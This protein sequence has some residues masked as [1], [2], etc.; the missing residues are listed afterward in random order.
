MRAGNDYGYD[1]KLNSQNHKYQGEGYQG[2]NQGY[3]GNDRGHQGKNQG[4]QGK[5]QG[6]RG[7]DQG[8][9]WKNQ[10][11]QGNG[12]GRCNGQPYVGAPYN[13][14][15][16]PNKVYEYPD[17]KLTAHD[18]MEA[19]LAS[20][21]IDY[22]I[23]AETPIII[24][25]GK[26]KFKKDAR[27]RY[28]IPGSTIRGLIRNNVQI[29]GLSG[30]EED[31]DD[32]ALMYRN[33]AYGAEK[34]RYNMVLG[35]P[36]GTDDS[37]QSNNIGVLLNVRAGY[38]SN[39]KGKYII[40]QTCVDSIKEE[41]KKMN[42][43][44]LSERKIIGDYLNDSENFQYKVF[45]PK[46]KSILQHKFEEFRREEKKGRV[47]YIGGKNPDYKPYCIQVSYRVE[48]KK[49][50]VAV[51][52]PGEY[53]NEGVA[54]STGKMNQKKAVYIIP[55]IDKSKTAIEIPERDIRAF[56]IDMKKKE[57]TL[58]QFGGR[59]YFD[60][61]EPGKMKPIFY[62]QS[63]DRLYFGFT[64][65]LRLFYDHTIKEGLKQKTKNGQIDYN[66]AMFGY[67]SPNGSYRSKI[68]FS[69]AVVQGEG[70]ELDRKSWILAEPKP[71]S[72]LDY[73]KPDGNQGV[74]Y[75]KD[76]F[77]L[78][79]VKQ[80]WLH[81]KLADG[82]ENMKNK[83]KVASTF[84]ALGKGTKFVGKIRFRN[85]TQDELGLLLWAVRL[86]PDSFMNV[87]KAKAYGYG[88]ISV[89][90][91]DAKRL[92]LTAAY[93]LEGSLDMNPFKCIDIDGAIEEYK[94]EIGRF[95]GD[96]S[97]DELPHIK[98]FFLM[99]DSKNIPDNEKT[100]YMKIDAKEYQSRKQ[101]LP[102]IESVIRGN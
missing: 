29:L 32:Y 94:K 1:K 25:D 37:A 92:D 77:E 51:G 78:R 38:V 24:D 69:D 61:P 14:V 31:I 67:A 11:Y 76:G 98:E 71:T 68:S 96:K 72:Y 3:R 88:N 2:K 33:V 45:R 4:H 97:I 40:Y 95:L 55:Q 86:N 15:S 12:A 74:T 27:G 18:R 80:Y 7:N 49:D 99:K 79:G 90:I 5:S 21:E 23:Q 6:Y 81:N 66:K 59:Q 52:E 46:G 20:G 84:Q 70:K 63:I 57:K 34:K 89:K 28:A 73:L 102:S 53:E 48:D 43:Y 39:E 50:I 9:Q 10:G 65:R 44:V 58:K 62:V 19:D 41:F 60:L 82:A 87:G 13:F 100:R 64:P 16:F 22:E 54:V 30:F 17:D 75:N 101:V 36:P 93:S 42:Y 8:Y 35:L 85:L 91:T 83:D 47:Q 56:Q 26:G